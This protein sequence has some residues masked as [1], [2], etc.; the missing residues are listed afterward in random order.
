M[1]SQNSDFK[2]TIS[3]YSL[4]AKSSTPYVSMPVRWQE[5][6]EAVDSGRSEAL[7]F[8]P[9]AAVKRMKKLGDLFEPVLEMRQKLRSVS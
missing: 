5:L 1:V 9:E 2:T 3:V 4:R 7:Y 6:R 8:E